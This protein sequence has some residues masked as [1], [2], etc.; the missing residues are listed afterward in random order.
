MLG[1]DYTALSQQYLEILT[2][3]ECTI[4]GYSAIIKTL[5]LA[6]VTLWLLKAPWQWLYYFVKM[7]HEPLHTLIEAYDCST[8]G[9]S[10]NQSPTADK[11]SHKSL[12]QAKKRGC[13]RK[14]KFYK[15]DFTPQTSHSF[16]IV[17]IL[18]GRARAKKSVL[19]LQTPR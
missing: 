17:S 4:I 5:N 18:K 19:K 6:R 15:F 2:K 16:V 9:R 11:R 8:Q 3:P 7:P 10:F 13:A 1:S 12:L 14:R